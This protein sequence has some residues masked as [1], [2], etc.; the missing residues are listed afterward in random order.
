MQPKYLGYYK[1]QE[2]MGELN[3]AMGKL[4]AFPGGVYWDG[5]DLVKPLEE[6]LVDVIAAITYFIETNNLNFDMARFNKKLEKFKEW[7]LTGVSPISEE[8]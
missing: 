8:K 5:R 7:G 6:E 2:E 4:A 1:V 3:Q